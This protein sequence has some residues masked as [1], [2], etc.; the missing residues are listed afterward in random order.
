MIMSKISNVDVLHSFVDANVK[1]DRL[2][3]DFVHTRSIDLTEISSNDEIQPLSNEMLD[4]FYEHILP[5]IHQNIECL[6]VESSSIHRLFQS[7]N[8]PKLFKFI[9]PE[10][11]LESVSEYFNGKCT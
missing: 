3:R 5:R 8:S 4:R 10:L 7:I 2:A 6:T 11:T 9:L 1:L